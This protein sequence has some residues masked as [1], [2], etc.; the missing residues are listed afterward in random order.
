MWSSS[1]HVPP[2]SLSLFPF[3]CLL[4]SPD[5]QSAREE[6]RERDRTAPY[7]LF[8]R[9][10]QFFS[11]SFSSPV[12]VSSSVQTGGSLTGLLNDSGTMPHT[13]QPH[14]KGTP[15]RWQISSD[16]SKTLWSIDDRCKGEKEGE[17]ERELGREAAVDHCLDSVFFHSAAQ[18]SSTRLLS[19]GNCLGMIISD[20][21][22]QAV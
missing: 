14:N 18:R 7:I 19:E 17:K 20:S 15:T 22:G 1:R 13:S 12:S 2:L 11:S 5:Q 3:P 9:V 16:C 21:R 6:K 4:F 10:L 8:N